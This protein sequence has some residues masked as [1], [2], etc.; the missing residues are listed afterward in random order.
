MQRWVESLRMGL[1]LF[2]VNDISMASRNRLAKCSTIAMLPVSRSCTDS[3]GNVF[4]KIDLR[5]G[6]L[7]NH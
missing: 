3:V 2:H 4:L 1:L 6:Y 5:F 7:C